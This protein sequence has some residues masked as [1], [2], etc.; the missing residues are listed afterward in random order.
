VRPLIFVGRSRTRGRSEWFRL[1]KP[2]QSH[3]LP[4]IPVVPV[5]DT[6]DARRLHP[7]AHVFLDFLRNLIPVVPIYKPAHTSARHR[8]TPLHKLTLSISRE[9]FFQEFR[10]SYFTEALPGTGRHPA[11][12]FSGAAIDRR[13]DPTDQRPPPSDRCHIPSLTREPLYYNWSCPMSIDLFRE[14]DAIA[15]A[16]PVEKGSFVF[17]SGDPASAVFVIRTG[18]IA[19]I[20]ADSKEVS[21]LDTFGPG[22]ILGLPAV[23][24][25]S[26]AQRRRLLRIQSWGLSG[27]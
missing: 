24:N 15:I 20:W 5:D 13:R 18:K 9:S 25:G 8:I 2:A 3:G 4:S 17:S 14:L 7:A 12:P 23:L 26:T 19:L 22:A 6:S 11:S 10:R 16:T 1:E 21:P 27:R